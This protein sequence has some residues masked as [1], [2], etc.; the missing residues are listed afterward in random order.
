MEKAVDKNSKTHRTKA[1]SKRGTEEN[2]LNLIKK[3]NLRKNY[4]KHILG[5]KILEA[6]PLKKENHN[7]H[8]AH[9]WPL[10]AFLTC[11][12]GHDREVMV[13]GL[14]C[15]P[16]NSRFSD[17]VSVCMKTES[18]KKVIT[19]EHS[20]ISRYTTLSGLHLFTWMIHSMCKIFF[21]VFF[22]IIFYWRIIAL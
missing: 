21:Y 6:V 19:R 13:Q 7:C 12:V 22:K 1:L 20:K 11:T 8:D 16:Q 14:P 5:G 15:K 10:R 9:P 2:F 17:G 4:S 18:S 3:E